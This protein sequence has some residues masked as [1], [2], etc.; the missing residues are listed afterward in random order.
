MFPCTCYTALSGTFLTSA[1]DGAGSASRSGPSTPGEYTS[2]SSR[3]S[4]SVDP[5]AGLDTL[6][7]IAF[8]RLSNPPP[9]HFAKSAVP[10]AS[11]SKSKAHPR[12]GHEGPDRDQRYSSTLSL[13]SA[14]DWGGWSAAGLGRFT[15]G[16]DPVPLYRRLGGC[17]GRSGR[18]REILAPDRDSIPGP[19]SP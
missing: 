8:P 19:S 1:I 9:I 4:I 5:S 15:P 6:D 18:V 16:K 13:T 10:I 7:R 2:D 14:L 11:V 17:Q 12:T 3:V